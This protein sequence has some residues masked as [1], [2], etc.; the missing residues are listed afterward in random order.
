MRYTNISED[1]G[2]PVE[3]TA[4]D[5]RQQAEAWGMEIEVSEDE[6]GIRRTTRIALR[7]LLG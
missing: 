6:D 3:V 1:W 4:A 2:D 7:L 5:Y